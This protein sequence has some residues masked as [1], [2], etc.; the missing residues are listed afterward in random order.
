MTCEEGDVFDLGDGQQIEAIYTPGHASGGLSFLDVKNRI[1]FTGG[2]H[3]DNTFIVGG[4]T[5]YPYECTMEAFK[6]GLERLR[7]KYLHRFDQIFAGHEI[8]PLD[9]CYIN[10]E[11]Q[12]VKDVLADR[13]CCEAS[14][15]DDEGKTVCRHMVR[16]AGIRY[17]PDE[18]FFMK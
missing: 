13:N 11:L 4:N 6:D 7:N 8:V 5:F 10:D 17:Y 12:A 16:D 2:M 15:T 1:L 9:S 14:W 3:S 18:S